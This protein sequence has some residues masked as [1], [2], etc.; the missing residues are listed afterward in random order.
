MFGN[1]RLRQFE[2]PSSMAALPHAKNAVIDLA[3]LR[4]YCLD[5]LHPRGR[6]KARVF[7]TALG[8]HQA[9]AGWL[10]AAIEAALPDCEGLELET[11]E[12]GARWRVDLALTRQGKSAVVRSL[13]IVRPGET[14]LRFVTCWVL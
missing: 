11:D 8:L 14:V 6:H 10:K 3:K 9:D 5:P 12:F 1:S 7:R 2:I 4:D 13:W